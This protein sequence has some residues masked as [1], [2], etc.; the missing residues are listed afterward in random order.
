M[1]KM[2]KKCS[3]D[4]RFILKEITSSKIHTL[5]D[6]SFA[7]HGKKLA[8]TQQHFIFIENISDHQSAF[9]HS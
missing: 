2:V 9:V 4:Q 5:V 6:I 7:N 1:K 8:F 3:T